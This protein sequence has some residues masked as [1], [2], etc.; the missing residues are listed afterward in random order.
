MFKKILLLVT[1]IVLVG[2]MLPAPA[3]THAQ[4][5]DSC[6][7]AGGVF[8]YDTD[9]CMLYAGFTLQIDY[10]IELLDRPYA[11]NT[12]D[13]FTLGL[14]DEFLGYMTYEGEPVPFFIA[15]PWSLDATYSTIAFNSDIYTVQYDIYMYMGGA[16]GNLTFATF[17]FDDANLRVI[18]LEDVFLPTATYMPTISAYVQADLNERLGES[19]DSQWIADGTGENIDNYRSFVLTPDGILFLFAPYQVAAYA[20]GPQEVLVPWSVLSGLLAE[21]FA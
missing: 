2:V 6:F 9:R 7:E 5:P 21:P 11:F 16:H 12:I 4:D 1:I 10:P 17:T 3:P 15:A 13:T 19:S 20:A 18:Q 8:D 14:R